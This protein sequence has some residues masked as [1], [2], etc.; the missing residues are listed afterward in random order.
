MNMS[1]KDGVRH[2]VALWGIPRRREMMN[3]SEVEH[4]LKL[5]ESCYAI[6]WYIDGFRT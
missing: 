4:L 5:L 3:D 6:D 2:C 1:K